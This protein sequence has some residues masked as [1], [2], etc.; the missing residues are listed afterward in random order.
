MLVKL[1]CVNGLTLNYTKVLYNLEE[2][3]I[4]DH[5]AYSWALHQH[6]I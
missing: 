1:N 4:S 2:R 6:P 5:R 3:Y